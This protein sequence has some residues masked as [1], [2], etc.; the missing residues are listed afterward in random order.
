[1]TIAAV[2]VLSSQFSEKV[3]PSSLVVGQY[4]C[5]GGDR[6]ASLDGQPR[7]AVSPHKHLSPLTECS[8]IEN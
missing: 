2:E 5:F 8:H 1:V 3:L 4:A 6:G 7:A